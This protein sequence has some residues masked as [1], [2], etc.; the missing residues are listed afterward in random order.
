MLDLTNKKAFQKILN[1]LVLWFMERICHV[2]H[3][4]AHSQHNHDYLDES[5]IKFW[6]LQGDLNLPVIRG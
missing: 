4:T 1:Q 6:K 3:K 5:T 2:H